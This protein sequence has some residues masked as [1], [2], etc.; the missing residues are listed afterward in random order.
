M[1]QEV[2]WWGQV[3]CCL[4]VYAF[5]IYAYECNSTVAPHICT[6][7]QSISP[8]SMLE[9]STLIAQ[10]LVALKQYQLMFQLCCTYVLFLLLTKR[11][12]VLWEYTVRFAQS[13]SQTIGTQNWGG[14]WTF[15]KITIAPGIK[16]TCELIKL[17]YLKWFFQIVDNYRAYS[18]RY[19][20]RHH[21]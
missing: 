13:K 19:P 7:P 2:S 15:L 1:N 14:F 6:V 18:A 16:I 3:I 21:K 8:F 17:K 11:A 9:S 20:T 4:P 5:M 10:Y 12:G